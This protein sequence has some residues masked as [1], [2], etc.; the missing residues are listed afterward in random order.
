[1]YK[2]IRVLLGNL[3]GRGEAWS[4]STS[5]QSDTDLRATGSGTYRGRHNLKIRLVSDGLNDGSCERCGIAE[6]RGRPITMALHHI[7]GDRLDNRLENLELLCPNCHSQ[8]D[9]YAGRN[10]RQ[11]PRT[12]KAPNVAPPM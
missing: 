8:T 3:V 1:M 11:T 9:T 7:S 10:G 12:R 5:A 4:H 2:R 6:W